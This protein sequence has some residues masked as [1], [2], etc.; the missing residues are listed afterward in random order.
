MWAII[1]VMEVHT[2]SRLARA[3]HSFGGCNFHLQLTPKYRRAVF[4][5]PEVR[6]VC[7]QSI[8]EK[9]RS[10]GILVGAMEFGQDHVHV[11]LQ[12]CKNYSVSYLSAQL[13]GYSAFQIRKRCWDK[14][15]KYLWGDHFW[16]S[17]YFFESV[18]RVTD[19]MV[20]FYIERQQRKHWQG[21]DYEYFNVHTS[22]KSKDQTTL[23]DFAM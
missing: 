22:G 10:M 6:D 23:A 12:G 21:D 9:A 4:R 5:I 18:G 14:V 19:D 13:K 20:K 7:R 11:F 8:V 15:R 17:G 1:K 2:M 3:K 16:S